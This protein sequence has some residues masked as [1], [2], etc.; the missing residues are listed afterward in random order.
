[1]KLVCQH[2]ENSMQAMPVQSIGVKAWMILASFVL[3]AT[4]Q[5][6]QSPAQNVLY[7]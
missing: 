5:P 6:H 7:T 1:M 4:P 2:R 3:H